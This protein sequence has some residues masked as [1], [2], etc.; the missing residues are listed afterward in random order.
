[1]PEDEAFSEK[2]MLDFLSLKGTLMAQTMYLKLTTENWNS[3][4]DLKNVYMENTN[5]YMPKA[6]NYWM[7]DEWFGAQRVQG[8]NPVL[9]TLCRKIPSKLGVTN[10]MM[11]SFL[12][13][14]TLDEAV[15]N[16]KIFMV[17][18]EIL[19]GVPTKEGE[20]VCDY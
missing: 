12:E 7:E 19:D 14:M 2:Y 5:M 4:D 17:D 18:L 9:I 15:N 3:L 11:N 1:M 16:N 20:T 10:E 13:G 6:A 8:V